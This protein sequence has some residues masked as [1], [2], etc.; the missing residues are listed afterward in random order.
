MSEEIKKARPKAVAS[1]S[2]LCRSRCTT[3]AP[4]R[5]S[6]ARRGAAISDRK[7]EQAEAIA[8]DVK[9]W[10]LSY[11]FFEDNPDKVAAAARALRRRDK[12]RNTPARDQSSL[13]VYDMLVQESRQLMQG[14]QAR[15]GRSQGAAGSANERGAAGDFGSGRV[16][17][18]RDRDGPCGEDA[19]TPAIAVATPPV[20]RPAKHRSPSAKP[21]SC[22]PRATRPRRPRNSPRR[23]G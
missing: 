8:L 22:W 6:F 11:G 10:G 3:D 21:T 18:A 12:I 23:S 7:F 19:G 9:G 4:P 5:R 1:S 16:G 2:W 15:R 17:A 14:R 13:A 20:A